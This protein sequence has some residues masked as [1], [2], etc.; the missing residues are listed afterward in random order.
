MLRECAV[1]GLL[2]NDY[3]I[4]VCSYC[5][6]CDAWICKQD[7]GDL[8][9]RA[10]AV[11]KRKKGKLWSKFEKYRHLKFMGYDTSGFSEILDSTF[12]V[13]VT[14]GISSPATYINSAQVAP[15]AGTSL[16]ITG[17]SIPTGSL[18]IV[19]LTNAG[20]GAGDTLTASDSNSDTPS[21]T[22]QYTETGGNNNNVRLA[23]FTAGT[24][25]TSVTCHEVSGTQ[26]CSAAWYSPGSLTGTIDKSTGQDQPATTSWTTGTTSTLSGSN[27]LVAVL[28]GDDN[29]SITSTYTRGTQRQAQSVAFPSWGY[30]DFNTTGTAGVAGSGTVT[31]GGTYL[32]AVVM[33]VK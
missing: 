18:I 13:P 3:R 4:K 33:A 24:T 5:S 9:R 2:D 19:G 20:G 10:V 25:I 12:G 1:C 23:L 26:T 27:D 16:S 11:Y 32:V 29:T 17:L 7:V 6:L 15:T 28:W 30:A 21:Y 14:S 22:A 31:P 8:V